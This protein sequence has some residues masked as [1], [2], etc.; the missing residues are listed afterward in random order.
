[1]F[2]RARNSGP[3]LAHPLLGNL[4]QRPIDRTSEKPYSD[5]ATRSGANRGVI[6]VNL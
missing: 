5:A 2:Q 1:M 4:R 3:R 6:R